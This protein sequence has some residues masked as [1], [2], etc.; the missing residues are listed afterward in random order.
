MA[1]VTPALAGIAA[2]QGKSSR[3][4]GRARRTLARRH[5]DEERHARLAGRRMPSG[6]TTRVTGRSHRRALRWNPADRGCNVGLQS[7]W[8]DPCGLSEWDGWAGG[9]E[10]DV[11]GDH[12]PDPRRAKQGPTKE[13]LRWEMARR[14]S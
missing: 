7:R 4:T 10:P 14:I 5:F 8:C 11:D 2:V 9:I 13:K 1:V 6:A 12:W 3:P